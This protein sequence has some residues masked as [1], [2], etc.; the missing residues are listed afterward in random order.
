MSETTGGDATE[1]ETHREELVQEPTPQEVREKIEAA[2][3]P[4]DGDKPWQRATGEAAYH[5]AAECLAKALLIVAD[6]DPSLLDVDPETEGSWVAANNEKLWEAAKQEFPGLNDWLGGPTGFQFGWAHNIVRF[7][8][9]VEPV[10]N[11]AVIDVKAD[12]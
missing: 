11:P 9:E 7:I 5:M 4:L 3:T 1:A 8:H 6:R 2:V 10:G 12:Q